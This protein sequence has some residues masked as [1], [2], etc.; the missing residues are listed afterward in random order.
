MEEGLTRPPDDSDNLNLEIDKL[1]H[2][3]TGKEEYS[4]ARIRMLE[5]ELEKKNREMQALAAGLDAR[6][7]QFRDREGKLKEIADKDNEAVVTFYDRMLKD[8]GDKEKKLL[9]EVKDLKEELIARTSEVEKVRNEVDEMRSRLN[10]AVEQCSEEQNKGREKDIFAQSARSALKDKEQEVAKIWH[11]LEETKAELAREKARLTAKDAAIDSLHKVRQNL[12]LDVSRVSGA[13]AQ[14]EQGFYE[15]AELLKKELKDK[16]HL[17]AEL[18]R[19]LATA[20]KRLGEVAGEAEGREKVL[21][22]LRA[23]HDAAQTA[24]SESAA[25]GRALEEKIQILL[26]RAQKGGAEQKLARLL[27]AKDEVNKNLSQKIQGLEDALASVH[28]EYADQ[29]KAAADEKSCVLLDLKRREEE[30]AAARERQ[31]ALEKELADTAER[32]RFADAQ[33]NNAVM[34]LRKRDNE[35]E[36]LNGRVASLE[37]E[38]ENYKKIS[39][40]AR[41]AA[42]DF[43]ALAD[44]GEN[45][46]ITKLFSALKDEASKYADLLKKHEDLSLRCGLLGAEKAQALAEAERLAKENRSLSAGAERKAGGL[47]EV[48]NEM[49]KE[50]NSRIKSLED[51]LSVERGRNADLFQAAEDE[52]KGMMLEL[53]RKEEETSS[54]G[55]RR[56]A[57]EKELADTSEKWRLAAA[58]LN[59]AV[60]NLRKRDNDIEMLNGRLASLEHECENYRKTATRAQSAAAEFSALAGKSENEQVSKLFAAL[61]S[62]GDRYAELQK[63]HEELGMKAGALD[64]EKAKALAEAGRLAA[65]NRALTEKIESGADRKEALGLQEKLK[66]AEESFK[67][68]LA[69]AGEAE[70]TRYE[71]LSQEMRQVGAQL[72]QKEL[73]LEATRSEL[74]PL[75]AEYEALLES[76][77][78]LSE[79]YSEE[80]RSES[81]AFE[82]AARNIRKRDEI[83]SRLAVSVSETRRE[84]EKLKAEKAALAESLR[85]KKAGQDKGLRKALAEAGK[86][87]SDKERRLERINGD[88]EKAKKEKAALLEK[89]RG[90]KA[91]R[92][93]GPYSSMLKD[94]EEKLAQKEK[95]L[96][97]LQSRMERVTADFTS[98]KRQDSQ[99]SARSTELSGDLAEL[100]AGISHQVSNSI[101]VIRSHAEFCLET[102]DPSGVKE[103][104]SVIVRNIV[105]LQKKIED[106]LEQH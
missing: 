100:L 18:E 81:A 23:E 52:K 68:E 88:L 59:N 57:V 47:L 103:S 4:A 14:G 86:K 105:L 83:L 58:Q 69:R 78:R 28:G 9:L 80:L 55:E 34:N 44:K 64:A 26:S 84:A 35:I 63:K 106:M 39:A 50:L 30:T 13:M 90:L 70:K 51:S 43:A 8:F 25:K 36:M 102:P 10:Q 12:E 49:I 5:A 95:L 62:E 72:R 22:A 16:E 54:S 27:E 6:E 46:Q 21:A 56:R 20:E 82:E 99:L 17:A 73:E 92:D 65:E 87:L 91:G 41:A 89:E 96:R 2:D 76:K 93:S 67:A 61:K 24:L 31:R 29:L 75:K 74:H 66:A 38:R 7:N 37:H 42:A 45:E 85:H 53:K 104:L 77:R 97:D 3:L 15:K 11:I 48:R 19:R 94:A 33:L 1:F 60:M 40:Q 101:S 71:A 98:L 32:W 79:K